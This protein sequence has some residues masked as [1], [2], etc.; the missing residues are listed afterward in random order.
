M[1][2]SD[3]RDRLLHLD[4]LINTSNPNLLVGLESLLNLGLLEERQV[5]Q[6]AQR[7]LCCP[8]PSPVPDSPELL[9][10]A[11]SDD[12]LLDPVPAIAPVVPETSEGVLQAFQDELSVRW[13]LFLGIFLVVLSSAVLAA[14]QWAYFPAAGQYAVLWGY[15]TIF[16]GMSGW[17]ARQS[18]LQLTA[19]TLQTS[20][21]LLVPLNFWAMDTFELW[22]HPLQ[23]LTV[24]IASASLSILTLFIARQR[25]FTLLYILLFLGSSVLHWGWSLAGFPL[26]SVYCVAIATSIVLRFFPQPRG[27]RFILFPLAV[28]LVRALF[29]ARLPVS[30]LGLALGIGGWLLGGLEAFAVGGHGEMGRWGD[31]EMGEVDSDDFRNSLSKIYEPIAL[32]LLLSG[33]LVAFKPVFPWQAVAVSVLAELHFLQRL[34]R[35]G[36]RRELAVLF[37]I[38][39]QTLF[40]VWWLFPEPIR[41]R[42]IATL[43]NFTGYPYI[44]WLLLSL[45][46]LAYL[47]AF[48]HFSGNFYQTGQPKLARFGERLGL[49]F[50][51]P[52]ATI[53]LFEPGLRSLNIF[54]LTLSFVLVAHRRPPARIRL[55][56]SSHLLALLTLCS[57]VHWLFFDLNP[58]QWAIF[59]LGL[60]VFEWGASTLQSKTA[61]SKQNST[62]SQQLRYLWLQ[63]CWH[64]GFVL[65]AVSYSLLARTFVEISL[66]PV[67][68]LA[69]EGAFG[70]EL[71]WLL[72]PFTL[73]GVARKRDG[74]RRVSAAW[75]STIALLMAQ[76]LTLWNPSVR[77]L[78]LGLATILM[79]VNARYLRRDL[80]VNLHLGFAIAFGAVLG[81]HRLLLPGQLLFVAVAIPILWLFRAVLLKR[82]G[83]FARLYAN[84]ADLWA[85]ALSLG[86]LILSSAIAIGCYTT[87]ALPNGQYA[88]A[89][90]I[91]A[92]AVLVRYA[93]A[94]N[95]R[96]VWGAS[97]ALE[98][99][100]AHFVAVLG[101]STLELAIANII[102]AFLLFWVT[103]GLLGRQTLAGLKSIQVLPVVYALMGLVL[104]A[105][106]LTAYTGLISVVAAF[107][108][109][110][111]S[112]RRKN[113][114]FVGYIA[115]AYLSLGW[116]ELIVYPLLQ[117]PQGNLADGLTVL[118]GMGSAIAI[119]YRFI[120]WLCG[121][122]H[123]QYLLGFRIANLKVI[124]HLHWVLGS[125][126]VAI[127]LPLSQSTSPRLTPLSLTLS[128][129]LATY[130]IFQGRT[131]R[132]S[133]PSNFWI[134]VGC[135]EY[136]IAGYYAKLV[137]L[138][139]NIFDEWRAMVAVGVA[140]ALFFI[141]WQRL[142]WPARPWKR[143][144]LSLPAIALVSTGQYLSSL[145][146]L[147]IAA[148]YGWIAR[149]ERKIRWSYATLALGNW[150][151]ARE[152]ERFSLNDP[153]YY[154]IP[155]G[156][157]ILYITRFD[158]HLRTSQQ[159]AARHFLRLL[160]IGLVCVIALL[161]HARSHLGV[162][163]SAIGLL[164][165]AAGLGLRVRAFLY[166]GTIT[167][168]LATSYQ[169]IILI[170]KYAFSKW[171][172]CFIAGVALISFAANFERGREQMIA[173][174]RNWAAQLKQWE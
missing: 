68:P 58:R 45:S 158:P 111:V 47:F 141:P 133:S 46:S 139:L 17:A 36:K 109:L 134:Y 48:I 89:A 71:L 6:L 77:L 59:L 19:Q 1:S 34:K 15:T 62:F 38:G 166:T 168:L 98:L 159:R 147:T 99:S 90:L 57:T 14:T 8:L 37:P 26:V 3:H 151:M 9:P 42:A 112:R 145:N 10:Q 31:G 122:I 20:A 72:V 127:A 171:I 13:L 107:I 12:E 129:I 120:V 27:M 136:S 103:E 128:S 92:V 43:Q 65:A 5:R 28:I 119:A 132:D 156:L 35:Y 74:M 114:K 164:A 167:F 33:W 85:I 30:E 169:L 41:G 54:L 61:Q 78:S 104:R 161:F 79:A 11:F 66:N 138:K 60:T 73:T 137:G 162:V 154:A 49:S 56:Y 97:W 124:A 63:S 163:P 131:K 170:N 39:L 110:G 115:I 52:I 67:P 148:F 93:K 101:G 16:G 24:A 88:I 64:F 135:L 21:L 69:T 153:L 25:E 55:I 118:A 80:A 105:G 155:I 29:V 149:R 84:S 157:S 50:G 174:A 76:G 82:S 22:N 108:G 146:L 87:L 7:S 165:I 100:L 116:Y 4:I 53:S 117:S 18:Q 96:A 51:I 125:L 126:L 91:V 172:V 152:F 83:R 144:S 140:I 121:Q 102:L 95:E 106:H 94:P 75:W 150:A 81:W 2:A 44:P 32:I 173:I 40:L 70:W 23:W 160:G 123:C 113:W 130:A 143:V 142:G 86:E